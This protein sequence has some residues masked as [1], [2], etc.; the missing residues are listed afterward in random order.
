MSIAIISDA[1]NALKRSDYPALRQLS[2]ETGDGELVIK[3]KVA[4]YYMKQL[5]QEAVMPVRGS[6]RLVN[7]VAVV[8]TYVL[9]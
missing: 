8:E 1:S 2:V 9:D 7:K 6:M 5:A 3:G 4:S